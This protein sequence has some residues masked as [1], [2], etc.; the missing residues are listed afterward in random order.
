MSGSLSAYPAL[1]A[2]Q[3]IQRNQLM[4]TDPSAVLDWANKANQLQLFPLEKQRMETTNQILQ[5]EQQKQQLGLN[6]QHLDNAT[7]YMLPLLL[8]PD[9]T[10]TTSVSTKDISKSLADMVHSDLIT[11]EESTALLGNLPSGPGGQEDPVGN[12]KFVLQ[13]YARMQ[14]AQHQT[15]QALAWLGVTPGTADTGQEIVGTGLAGGGTANPG[16]FRTTQAP[17]SGLQTVPTR[18]QLGQ[19]VQWEDEN[20][21]THHGTYAE[22]DQQ[23]GL[24]HNL[25]PAVPTGGGGG[26]GGFPAGVSGRLPAAGGAQGQAVGAAPGQLSDTSGP[27]PT[28]VPVQQASGQQFIKDRDT[29]ATLAQ[30]TTPLRQMVSLLEHGVE[31]GPKSETMNY[32]RSLLISMANQGLLPKSITPDQIAQADFDQFKKW[33]AQYVTGQPFS[34]G[35]DARMAEFI[36]G[37]PN[38]SLST[39]ANKDVAKTLLGMERFRSAPYLAFQM[40]TQGNGSKAAGNYADYAANFSRDYDPRAFA[41]DLMG[42]VDSP[43]VKKMYQNLNPGEKQKFL[44]SLQMAYR[45]P[46]LLQ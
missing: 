35:S 38:A 34:A 23:R 17:G 26:A 21:V 42:G 37:S 15:Q 19:P 32:A 10:P 7:G 11:P 22:Y 20:G 45:I 36:S 41:V 24:G 1:Q 2:G 28:A 8:N 25:G 29:A 30:R 27:S 9:G 40:Q 16:S 6:M 14:A 43:Q 46:G 3:G 44:K 13:H 12:R 18:A 39:V 33:S 31:T 5:L 4:S